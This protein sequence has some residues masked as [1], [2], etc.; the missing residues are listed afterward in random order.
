MN[1]FFWGAPSIAEFSGYSSTCVICQK[2]QE[3][4]GTKFTCVQAHCGHSASSAEVS[5]RLQELKDDLGEALRLMESE[6]PGN[7]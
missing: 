6:R 2:S 1:S 3:D 7:W 5:R 4:A